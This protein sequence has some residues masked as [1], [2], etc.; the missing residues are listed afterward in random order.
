MIE[1]RGSE[2]LQELTV[3]WVLPFM[4]PLKNLWAEILRG[5]DKSMGYRG[6]KKLQL[7]HTNLA[8]LTPNTLC[9]ALGVEAWRRVRRVVGSFAGLFAGEQV[10]N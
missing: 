1:N 10:E 9:E 2:S 6:G 7:Y 5:V 8:Y 4:E 3:H